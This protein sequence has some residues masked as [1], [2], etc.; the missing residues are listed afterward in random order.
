[1]TGSGR[2]LRTAYL[3][4]SVA[5]VL[6][7][8]LSVAL[9]GEWPRRVLDTQVRQMA[10]DKLMTLTASERR[11]RDVYARE[12]CAYCHTQQVRFLHQDMQRF[13]AP[14]LAWETHADTPHLWGT[15]RIGPDLS[16]ESGVRT[17]DW[18]LTH[19]YAPRSIVRDSVMPNYR[20]LFDGAA[21]RPRQEALDLVAYLETLGRE[22]ELAGSEGEAKAKKACNCAD[23]EMMAMAFEAPEVNVHPARPRRT[24]EVPPL[25]A[26]APGARGQEVFA[27][28]CAGCHGPRGQ[29]DG[30]AAATLLPRPAN[31]TEHRYN[32][33]GLATTLWHGVAGASMPAWRDQSAADLSAVATFVQSLGP[34]A[35]DPPVPSHLTALGQ[36]VY[37]SHCVSCHGVEGDGRGTA[38][39]K[40]AI[41]PANFTT[42]QPTVNAALAAI[43]GGIAGGPMAPWTDRLS[44][45]E[46]V[47]VAAHVRTFYRGDVAP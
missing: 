46:I 18:H 8:A 5:G 44:D 40:L 20:S 22:R 10:P 19:L 38:A 23:D 37:A 31:L 24:G 17:A 30:P 45:A 36:R 21:D 9:L 26:S 42:K 32:R 29:G 1:M 12:G 41:A 43:R 3:V 35:D 15:R 33:T 4:A 27:A 34:T 14:T 6:F 16:R 7:F 13:G 11:G 28:E 39:D 25:G 47:A 2:A